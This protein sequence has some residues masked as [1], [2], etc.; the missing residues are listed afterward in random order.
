MVHL[1]EHTH[2]E[3]FIALMTQFMPKWQFYR[4]ALN[5]LPVQHESWD[6]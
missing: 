2:K 6:Y 5:R 1:L 3:R 4:G